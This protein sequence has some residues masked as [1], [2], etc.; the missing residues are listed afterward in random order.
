MIEGF[1]GDGAATLAEPQKMEIANHLTWQSDYQKLYSYSA[2]AAVRKS[3]RL[4]SSS[5]NFVDEQPGIM[6]DPEE[7]TPNDRLD[8]S[9]G[10]VDG[11]VGSVCIV[12]APAK[13]NMGRNLVAITV[14]QISS[15]KNAWMTRPQPYRSALFWWIL[16]LIV[17]PLVFTSICICMILSERITRVVDSMV[18]EAESQSRDLEV[19][20]LLSATKLKATQAK[21]E[22]AQVI[23]NLHILTRVAGWL[24]FD[25]IT[26]SESFTHVTQAS[27]ECSR[28]GTGNNRYPIEENNLCDFLRDK[29][30]APCAC[31]WNDARAETCSND[32]NV[33]DTRYLQNGFFFLQKRDYDEATG[34]R[35][36]ARSFGTG[37]DD[38]PQNTLWWD[39]VNELPGAEKGSNAS[40][41]ETS[42]DRLR[43]S[44][45]AAVVEAAL[46]NYA[47]LPQKLVQKEVISTFIGF[48]ADGMVSLSTINN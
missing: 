47:N 24:L 37:V 12:P 33:S 31:D 36:I 27:Q 18:S 9:S 29:Y 43:V 7:D 42:Y 19:K 46:Y 15:K 45:A 39:D 3:V 44:S 13:K 5:G 17:A 28:S 25:G 16:I 48:E 20:A 1:S 23:R 34:N 35:S 6:P 10:D 11:Q 30:K 22:I 38:S 2:E 14:R 4:P 21:S 26:R 40:G 32:Y 8:I 41:Y